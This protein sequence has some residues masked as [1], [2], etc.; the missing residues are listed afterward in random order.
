MAL[1]KIYSVDLL[2]KLYTTRDICAI[3][4][5]DKTKSWTYTCRRPVSRKPPYMYIYVIRGCDYLR[6]NFGSGWV[7]PTPTSLKTLHH[8]ILAPQYSYKY[9]DPETSSVYYI[10]GA[11]PQN[12]CRF[13]TAPIEG[14]QPPDK[15]LVSTLEPCLSIDSELIEDFVDLILHM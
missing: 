8:A 5:L 2:N 12:F 15:N 4:R 11:R 14:R 6:V 1:Y 9:T 7:Q 3:G 13:A 10:I